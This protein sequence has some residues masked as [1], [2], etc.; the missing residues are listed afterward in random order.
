MPTSKHCGPVEITL[1]N[2]TYLECFDP[3]YNRL[4]LIPR[5]ETDDIEHG[6]CK[7]ITRDDLPRFYDRA[8]VIIEFADQTGLCRHIALLQGYLTEDERAD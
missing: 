2:K 7:D 5:L 8:V 1:G 4:L 6:D 3:D